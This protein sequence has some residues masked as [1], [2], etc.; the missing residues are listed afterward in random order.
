MVGFPPLICRIRGKQRN[1]SP[2]HF[3]HKNGMDSDKNINNNE[4]DDYRQ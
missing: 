3:F 1:E 2:D 4:V